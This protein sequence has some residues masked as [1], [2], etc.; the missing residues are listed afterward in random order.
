MDAVSFNGV[1][2]FSSVKVA[3]K[4]TSPSF[5][6]QII[7]LIL[8][9]DVFFFQFTKIGLHTFATIL[10]KVVLYVNIVA[11]QHFIRELDGL[12]YRFVLGVNR[13]HE[14]HGLFVCFSFC[15]SH[16]SRLKMCI[17]WIEFASVCTSYEVFL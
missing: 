15:F 5:L 14:K 3:V 10:A 12:L 17:A 16:S 1:I 6:Q 7:A 2:I 8:K 9:A 13:T 11:I 4:V